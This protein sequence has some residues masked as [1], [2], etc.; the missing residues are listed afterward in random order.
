MR[1]NPYS[2]E[3]KVARSQRR[4]LQ[5]MLDKLTD[6]ASEWDGLSGALECDLNQRAEEM[7]RQIDVLDEQIK[8]W[9]EG[10]G[11]REDDL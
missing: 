1:R 2:I 11:D 7:N 9:S 5:T 6:M 4:R 10:N 8:D 3:L